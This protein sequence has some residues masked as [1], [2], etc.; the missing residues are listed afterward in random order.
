MDIIEK[1][2]VDDEV[3]DDIVHLE[4]DTRKETLIASYDVVRK[5]NTRVLKSNKKS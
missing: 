3:E 4:P 5:D 2:N 1:N